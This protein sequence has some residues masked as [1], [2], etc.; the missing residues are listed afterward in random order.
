MDIKLEKSTFFHP[1]T[2]GQTKVVNRAVIHL[3]QGY[4]N[5]H[6]KL[7]HEQFYYV[8]DVYNYSIHSSTLRSPFETCF[9]YS[10]KSPL[11]FTF[12]KYLVVDG[13]NDVDKAKKFI[14]LVH[15]DV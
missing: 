11:D 6:P 8:Q 2:D 15:Q 1:Q 3:L 4:C 5:K 14:Q 10:F 7:W 9:G 13:C 12:G